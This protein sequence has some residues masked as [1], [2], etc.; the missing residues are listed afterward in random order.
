[1]KH[2]VK[3]FRKSLPNGG[4]EVAFAED[5]GFNGKISQCIDKALDSL[6][7]GIRQSLYY[8]ISKK[9]K[10]PMEQI[11]VKP[12]EVIEHLQQ[13]LGPT[14]SS[15]VQ[16]LI[17]REISNAFGLEFRAGVSLPDAIQQARTKFLN[18]EESSR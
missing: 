17:I 15:F 7:D 13:I 5:K 12:D 11:V 16:K 1:M 4:T 8:Q 3:C 6:G 10:L 9:Y 14:G 18:V 2:S